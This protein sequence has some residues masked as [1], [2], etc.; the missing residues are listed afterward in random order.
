MIKKICVWINNYEVLIGGVQVGNV[1]FH[2][3]R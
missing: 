2:E 3:K 1:C